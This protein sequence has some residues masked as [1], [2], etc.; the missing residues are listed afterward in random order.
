[1]AVTIALIIFHIVYGA[2]TNIT[3]IPCGRHP[4]PNMDTDSVPL[5]IIWL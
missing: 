1:V 5:A 4:L 3:W 2:V